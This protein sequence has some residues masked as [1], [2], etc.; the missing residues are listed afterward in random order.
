[1]SP[2]FFCSVDFAYTLDPVRRAFTLKD[3]SM[4]R[5]RGE[6]KAFL[7]HNCAINSTIRAR[8]INSVAEGLFCLFFS[9]RGGRG[10]GWEGWLL[11]TPK[12]IHFVPL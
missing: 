12:L 11:A 3:I 10:E 4:F 9:W 2:F 7:P 1:M 6:E 8:R 5:I